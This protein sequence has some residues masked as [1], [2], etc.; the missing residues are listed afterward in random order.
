M[1]AAQLAFPFRNAGF[2]KANGGGAR[3]LILKARKTSAQ[4]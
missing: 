1:F 2:I 4:A 3:S